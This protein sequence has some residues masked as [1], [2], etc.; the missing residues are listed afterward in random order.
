VSSEREE[1]EDVGEA[2]R[3][4]EQLEAASDRCRF[5]GGV[6]TR[7][8]GSALRFSGGGGNDGEEAE[9]DGAG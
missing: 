5:R 9:L 7:E 8:H 4:D 2:A 6:E 1:T 3:V